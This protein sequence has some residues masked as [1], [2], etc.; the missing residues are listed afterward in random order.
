MP[1]EEGSSGGQGLAGYKVRLRCPDRW[2]VD[3]LFEPRS[4]GSH[5]STSRP[6]QAAQGRGHLGGSPRST[7]WRQRTHHL[8]L[9]AAFLRMTDGCIPTSSRCGPQ[10]R[11]R[12]NTSRCAATLR[13]GLGRLGGADAPHDLEV[14]V[15]ITP[16][17]VY[18]HR[19]SPSS[20]GDC[21]LK[22]YHRWRITCNDECFSSRWVM[23]GSP[24]QMSRASW[25]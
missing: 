21:M 9:E 22:R 15:L 18:R 4:N 23:A 2:P 13:A 12:E 3:H 5:R 19:V 24:D 16:I 14:T 10:R 1:V 25:P 20:Y 17:F 8:G 7:N 11:H 6:R